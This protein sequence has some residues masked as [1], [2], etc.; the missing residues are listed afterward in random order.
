MTIIVLINHSIHSIEENNENPY[1]YNFIEWKVD[2][3]L[4]NKK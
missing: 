1:I 4:S 2:V 3:A